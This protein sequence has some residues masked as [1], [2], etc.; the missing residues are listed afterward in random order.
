MKMFITMLFA[1]AVLMLGSMPALISCSSSGKLEKNEIKYIVP[2]VY[3]PEVPYFRTYYIKHFE[4]KGIFIPE[5]D[6]LV[7]LKYFKEVEE[8]AQVLYNYNEVEEPE[9]KH[10]P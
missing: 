9:V 10:P 6:F 8:A 4:E 7:V 1:N 2:D 5:N 3:I